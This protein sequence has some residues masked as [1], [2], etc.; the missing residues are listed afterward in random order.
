MVNLSLS[1]SQDEPS[2]INCSIILPPYSSFHCQALSRNPSLPRSSFSIPSSL[3]F[4]IILTSVA[5]L[6]WSV[7]G[8]QRAL[9]PCILLNRIRISCMVL[10]KAWPMCSC[11]VILGGGITI[12][13]GFLLLSTSA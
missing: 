13:N 11:P 5:I 4:S 7:P 3:S 9:Y 8:C 2:F 12:V 6:A 10:S 1:Q